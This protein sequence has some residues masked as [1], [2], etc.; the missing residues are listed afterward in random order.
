MSMTKK[1][2][3]A[4][5]DIV[6]GNR[7]TAQPFRTDWDEGRDYCLDNVAEELAD[8]FESINPNFDRVRFE[9]ACD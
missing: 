5:A 9:K 7:P 1:D 4:I 3:E 6:R 2:F 8:Y